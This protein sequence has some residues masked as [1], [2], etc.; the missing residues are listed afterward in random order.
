M[1]CSKCGETLGVNAKFCSK[2][3]SSNA[4][5]DELPINIS[6]EK[7][8]KRLVGYLIAAGGLALAIVVAVGVF[9]STNSERLTEE[10]IEEKWNT[11]LDKCHLVVDDMWVYW[12]NTEGRYTLNVADSSGTDVGI[13]PDHIRCASL[14]IMGKDVTELAPDEEI[15]GSNGIIGRNDSGYEIYVF[16]WTP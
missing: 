8:K 13:T 1:Q 11:V 15:V 12:E 5:V 4:G 7:N 2:C 14:S 9:V 3:G 16:E 6:A 10:N